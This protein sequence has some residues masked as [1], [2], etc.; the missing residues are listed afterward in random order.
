MENVRRGKQSLTGFVAYMKRKDAETAVSELDGAEW[1]GAKL[2]VGFSKP[3]PIPQRA[4]YGELEPARLSS[5]RQIWATA[6]QARGNVL[7]RGRRD[8]HRDMARGRARLNPLEVEQD[9]L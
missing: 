3:V 7:G 8:V 9:R 2:K 4:V 5:S 1:G 6:E